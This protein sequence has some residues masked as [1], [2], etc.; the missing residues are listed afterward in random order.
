[1]SVLGPHPP[2]KRLDRQT[3]TIDQG[4][5]ER[6]LA[7]AEPEQIGGHP[8]LAVAVVTGSD[9]DHRDRQ[10]PPQ[11]AS[12]LRRHMFEHQGEAARRLQILGLAAQALL[13]DRVVGLAPIAEPMHRLGSQAEVPHHRD[14]TTHQAINHHKGFRFSP[15]QLHGRRRRLLKNPSGCRHSLIRPALIAQEGQIADQQGLLT[16]RSAQAPGHGAG[17]VN[18]L[19]ERHR[20]GG[21]VTQRHHRQ[22]ITHKQRLSACLLHPGRRERIPGGQQPDRLPRLFALD[23]ITG[24]DRHDRQG[25]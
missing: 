16:G 24:T 23:E 19:V 11:P 25:F 21:G 3:T 6:R 12:Q 14:A 8:H 15:L 5:A 13:A 7:A 4:R 18:H 2:L 17:V 9:A 10:L 1:M 22:R 20:Q